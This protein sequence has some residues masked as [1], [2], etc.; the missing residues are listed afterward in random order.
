M[1]FG[2]MS[3]N[4]R[5][6][7]VFQQDNEP[8][9][10]SSLCKGYLTKKEGDGAASDDLTSTI[11]WPQPNWDGFGLVGLQSERKAVNTCS[12]YVG[13]QTVGK[14]FHM[15]LVERMPRVCKA[16]VK[17]KGGYFEESEIYFDLTLFWLPHDSMCVISWFWCLHY[18]STMQKIV[19]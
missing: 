16:V 5:L 10:T 12:A 18:Y 15:K 13:T 6:S 17:A 4:L 7:F 14:A 2:L 11:T 3:P 8:K 9:H 19:K 1:S